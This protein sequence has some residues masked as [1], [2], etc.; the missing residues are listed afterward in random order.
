MIS[1]IICSL[2]K[3]I[4][5]SLAINIRTTIG[6]EY[7]IIY[8]Y[9]DNNRFSI[10]EA[11]NIG[12]S[13]AKYSICCFMHDDIIYHSNNWGYSILHYFES[14]EKLGAIAVSGNKRGPTAARMAE[15]G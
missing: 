7:E 3:E 10:F 14:N 2:H 12:T 15:K 6:I 5:K 11:Y 4:D 9:N 1:I 13:K 8:I